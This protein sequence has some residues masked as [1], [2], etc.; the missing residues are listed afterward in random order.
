MSTNVNL[1]SDLN[2]YLKSSGSSITN[3][4]SQ[5]TSKSIKEWFDGTGSDMKKG[6]FSYQPLRTSPSDEELNNVGISSPVQN[7]TSRTNSWFRI[8]F[9]SS[10][11]EP[12]GW[13]PTLT[14][15]Q[16]IIG[17][18][19]CFFM[20]ITC[21]SISAMYIPILLFAARK[22]SILFTFGSIFIVASFAILL[23]PMNHLKHQFSKERLP[24][25]AGYFGSL[26][27]TLYFA[28]QVQS[29]ILTS[30]FAIIQVIALIWYVV[31][32]I[33]GGQTGLMF[34]SKMAASTVSKTLPV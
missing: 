21:F 3:N 31:T 33:P 22:F 14:R 6:W 29:T 5:A 23:G 4:Q 32:Y 13:F 9:V 1:S 26:I 12:K 16:R 25:T 18:I 30:I 15:T 10:E 34:F 28:L 17:F 2:N 27:A 7:G 24:F 20:G 11:P 8:P 19:T